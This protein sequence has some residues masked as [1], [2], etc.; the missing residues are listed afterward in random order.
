M[1]TE[2]MGRAGT[3]TQIWPFSSHQANGA[4]GWGELNLCPILGSE[5]LGEVRVPRGLQHAQGL[6]SWVPLGVGIGVGVGVT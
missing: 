5:S 6:Q 2:H 3:G 4:W 1:N